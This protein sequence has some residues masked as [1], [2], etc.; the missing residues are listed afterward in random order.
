MKEQVE[1]LPKMRLYRLAKECGCRFIFGSDAHSQS[2]FDDYSIWAEY[3]TELL[4][5]TEDDIIDFAK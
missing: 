4:G 1:A 2:E 5:L 3:V